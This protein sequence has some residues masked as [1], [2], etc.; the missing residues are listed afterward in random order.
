MYYTNVGKTLKQHY[1]KQTLKVGI[2]E[3]LE[4]LYDDRAEVEVRLTLAYTHRTRTAY[5]NLRALLQNSIAVL[6]L[7]KGRKKL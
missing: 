1:D 7:A 3:R 4:Q 6:E 5:R 2:A